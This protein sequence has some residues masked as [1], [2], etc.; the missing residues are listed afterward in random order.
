MEIQDIHTLVSIVAEI[1]DLGSYQHKEHDGLWLDN[2]MWLTHDECSDLARI[3]KAHDD[4]YWFGQFEQ[5]K[6]T[7]ELLNSCS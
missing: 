1:I 2:P 4:E 7:I 6:K 3:I 5:N